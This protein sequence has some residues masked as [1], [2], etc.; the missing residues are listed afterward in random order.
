MHALASAWRVLEMDGWL[1]DRSPEVR[2]ALRAIARVR[3][4]DAGEYLFMVGDRANGMFGLVSGTLDISIPRADGQE[5]TI[6]RADTGFW[7][8]DL[9]LASR[10][11]SPLKSLVSAASRCGSAGRWL[12]AAMAAASRIS[13][14]RGDDRFDSKRPGLCIVL[15]HKSRCTRL[16]NACRDGS[17]FSGGGIVT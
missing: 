15:S 6:H 3:E 13:A 11:I 17:C 9:A 10:R 5:L 2:A 16:A 7:F 14:T 12:H 1:S 4:L 8:G